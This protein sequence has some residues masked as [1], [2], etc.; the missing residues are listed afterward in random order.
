MFE[1]EHHITNPASAGDL[2]VRL[3]HLTTVLS[4]IFARQDLFTSI[5]LGTVRIANNANF[6]PSQHAPQL[7]LG[8]FSHAPGGFICRSSRLGDEFLRLISDVAALYHPRIQW[9]KVNAQSGELEKLCNTQADLEGRLHELRQSTSDDMVISC[10]IAAF[11]CVYAFWTDIWDSALIPRELSKQMLHH[12]RS[13]Q[14]NDRQ[15]DDG[16]LFWLANVGKAFAVDPH[17]RHGLDEMMRRDGGAIADLPIGGVQANGIL[18]EFVWSDLL[19]QE[20]KG[21]F[22]ERIVEPT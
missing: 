16:L 21:W 19:Y 14:E 12:I 6:H 22:W 8:S 1:K 11:L 18:H 7:C 13:W 17:V 20:E 5:F 3:F 10:I 2:L 15:H 4:L 9:L